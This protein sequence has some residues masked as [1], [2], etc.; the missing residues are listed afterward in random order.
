[1][2][3]MNK[4]IAFAM[5]AI[6]VSFLI[7]LAILM[8]FFVLRVHI[9]RN[10]ILET[11]YNNAQLALLSLLSSTHTDSL[12]GNTKTVYEIIPESM[13]QKNKPDLS[14]LKSLLNEF[15]DTN[16]YKLYYIDNGQE[17]ILANQGD[18]SKF[19]TFEAETL[20]VIPHNSGQLF[21]ELYLVIT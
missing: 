5:G 15:V 6:I 2:K 9:E 1:M 7:M 16:I 12:D 18:F 19:E 14:F 20:I 3:K 17:R 4:G 10:V 8:P 21:K 11:K 13:S